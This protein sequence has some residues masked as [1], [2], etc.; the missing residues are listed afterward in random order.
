MLEVFVSAYFYLVVLRLLIIDPP[1]LSSQ[2]RSGHE[3]STFSRGIRS[4]SV[5]ITEGNS[6]R[7]HNLELLPNPLKLQFILVKF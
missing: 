3:N 6:F 1:T 7:I 5:H 4:L 2:Q